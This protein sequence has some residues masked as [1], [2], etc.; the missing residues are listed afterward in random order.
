MPGPRLLRALASLHLLSC[1]KYVVSWDGHSGLH[2]RSV[3]GLLRAI[4]IQGQ[5]KQLRFAEC[6]LQTA[7]GLPDLFVVRHRVQHGS[8]VRSGFWRFAVRGMSWGDWHG[9]LQGFWPGVLV[10]VNGLAR[11]S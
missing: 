4:G 10:L 9:R 2:R 11:K 5:Q 1:V 8:A 6:H 3:S 7:L